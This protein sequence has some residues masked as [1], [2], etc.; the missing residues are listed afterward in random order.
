MASPSSGRLWAV[1]L[2]D[3]GLPYSAEGEP[4]VP[5][6]DDSAQRSA[7]DCTL[8]RTQL[9]VPAQSTVVIGAARDQPRLS[10]E[11]ATFPGNVLIQPSDRGSAARLLW[12]V[13]WIHRFDPDAVVVAIPAG[14]QMREDM[15]F[16]DHLVRVV[17]RV[18]NDPRWI[19]IVGA[20]PVEPGS[21]HAWIIRAECLH[22]DVERVWRVRDLPEGAL[23]P[24]FHGNGLWNTRVVVGQARTFIEAAKTCLPRLHAAFADAAQHAGTWREPAAFEEAYGRIAACDFFPALRDASFPRIAASCLPPIHWNDPLPSRQARPQRDVRAAIDLTATGSVQR[25][26]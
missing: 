16:M 7:L 11:T 12:P 3:D 6:S 21:D 2:V 1:V 4:P 24:G 17:G 23:S 25:V 13:Y 18:A 22:D 14:R 8:R 10:R 15:V 19:V 9:A 5:F 20:R 26:A